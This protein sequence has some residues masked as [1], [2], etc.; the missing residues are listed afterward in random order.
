MPIPQI[1][2]TP[3]VEKGGKLSLPWTLWFSRLLEVLKTGFGNG[4]AGTA[5]TTKLLGTGTG[6]AAPQTV[7]QYAEVNINGTIYWIPLMQ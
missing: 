4:A 5:V 1:Q 6:P 7:V 3:V 2:Q